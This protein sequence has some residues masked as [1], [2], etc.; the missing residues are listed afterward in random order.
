MF[1]DKHLLRN[2]VNGRRART[3][4]DP[5]S[6][7]DVSLM[8]K[9]NITSAR[10]SQMPDHRQQT[11]PTHL[12]K[13]GVLEQILKT[14]TDNGGDLRS[15]LIKL[16]NDAI[17]TDLR[18]TSQEMG[19][20]YMLVCQKKDYKKKS[21]R[22]TTLRQWAAALEKSD[23]GTATDSESETSIHAK[24]KVEERK[25]WR[26]IAAP[27]TTNVISEEQREQWRRIAEPSPSPEVDVRKRKR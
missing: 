27:L 26:R 20:M 2:A 4:I 1:Q 24:I 14:H 23:S 5:T 21:E 17:N 3:K 19:I 18:F 25:L 11:L 6:S 8:P 9:T 12:P 13:M 7:R 22:V 10:F 16:L 15:V